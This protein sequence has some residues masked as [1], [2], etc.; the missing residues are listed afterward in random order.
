MSAV[1]LNPSSVIFLKTAARD[2]TTAGSVRQP[3]FASSA[4]SS[5]SAAWSIQRSAWPSLS[6]TPS[7]MW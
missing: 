5:A 4:S 1:A 2:A 7:F 6:C 3:A